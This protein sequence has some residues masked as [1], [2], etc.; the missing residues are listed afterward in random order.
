MG[1]AFTGGREVVA[2]CGPVDFTETG[3]VLNLGMSSNVAGAN[4]WAPATL[5]DCKGREY[6]VGLCVLIARALG[7]GIRRGPCLEIHSSWAVYHD[8]LLPVLG[9]LSPLGVVPRRRGWRA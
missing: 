2:Q 4:S 9:T 3:G 5:T 6:G 1:L 7:R 8:A